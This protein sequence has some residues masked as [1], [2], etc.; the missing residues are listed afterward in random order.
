[1]HLLHVV[2]A[3]PN[4]PKLA[5]VYRAGVA[6]GVRQTVVHTG[7]HYDDAMSASFLRE[8]GL[9]D[10][11]HLLEVGSASHAVQ[12]ARVM[13]RFEP[14]LAS[15]QPDWVVVYGDVNSTAA[16]ALVAAKLGIRV[17]HVEAGL[18]SGDRSMPEEIN[19]LVT[20]RLADLLLTPSRDAE[21]Q[22]R[23]EGEPDEEIAF[24]GNVMIDTL[25]RAHRDALA[26][27]FRLSLGL[28]PGGYVPV[29]LHRPSNVDDPVRLRRLLAELHAVSAEFPVVLPL[30][31]RTRERVAAAGI[32]LDWARVLPP[33]PYLHMLDLV[34][35]A[36]AVVTDSGGLQ[37][38]TTVLGV[39][40]FTVRDS[41][42][43]PVTVSEGTNTLVRDLDQLSRQVR[44]AT[45]PLAPR[46]P[47]GWDGHAGPRVITALRD[48]L[49]AL[50]GA[51]LAT[52]PPRFVFPPPEPS[53]PPAT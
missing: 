14:V 19:R 30:H 38:E 41:T 27:G 10:P 23:R 15:V 1:M 24:V 9:P 34:D 50:R 35:G 2:G 21:A 25:L 40:C 17:A 18:R 45:R 37:E 53:R 20:D 26:T 39:P 48:R 32:S 52:S 4:F 16:A 43:R 12:T 49:A 44:A 6:A 13:E 33:V 31:P 29:T 5:P 28:A 42:E 3:R 8:L 47:E 51:E 22:L 7:Q 46:R 36:H 11:D